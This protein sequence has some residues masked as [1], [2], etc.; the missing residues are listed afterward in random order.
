M[1]GLRSAG[2]SSKRGERFA[3]CT[4]LTLKY[5]GPYLL[6]WL[7]WHKLAGIERIF[8]YLDD[9]L[10]TDAHVHAPILDAV[11][12]VPWV[13]VTTMCAARTP[14]L[15]EVLLDCARRAKGEGFV[16]M[17][18]WDLDESPAFGP[19]LLGDAP[20]LLA[21]S[22]RPPSFPA[23]LA[24]AA[25]R[26][27]T[28]A[29]VITRVSFGDSGHVQPPA[30]QLESE[31]YT[32]RLNDVNGPGKL[33]WRLDEHGTGGAN[34]THIHNYFM[35]STHHIF[36]RYG[37]TVRNMDGS[38]ASAREDQRKWEATRWSTNPHDQGVIITA[39]DACEP[40]TTC[41]DGGSAVE[42]VD[43]RLLPVRLHHYLSRSQ[44][45]C[46]KKGRL[47][48]RALNSGAQRLDFTWRAIS[49]MN[50]CWLSRPG[51][52]YGRFTRDASL[53]QYAPA[54]RREVGRLFGEGA[55]AA[56]FA[57]T[58]ALRAE[59]NARFEPDR[60]RPNGLT[61]FAQ[62]LG[63]YAR[64]S[65]TTRAS[66][67]E[68]EGVDRNGACDWGR[69]AAIHIVKEPNEYGGCRSQPHGRLLAEKGEHPHGGHHHRPAAAGGGPPQSPSE[70]ALSRY[71]LALH[72][73]V[74][75][76]PGD[77]L[78]RFCGCSVYKCDWAIIAKLYGRA[79]CASICKTQPRKCTEQEE[80]G[81]N[82]LYPKA[83]EVWE[84]YVHTAEMCNRQMG[85]YSADFKM[86]GYSAEII[87]RAAPSWPI[88]LPEK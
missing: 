75:M 66:A 29:L 88:V 32:E 16:W 34:A 77:L 31:A 38:N 33:V 60:P 69:V 84:P 9:P 54:V 76:G 83:V 11:G 64:K 1:P 17:A 6:P 85:G 80:I 13:S 50:T 20:P 4:M 42:R 39:M 73:Y 82:L 40:D 72:C 23:L 51:R 18:N 58:D 5:E 43:E 27:P 30:G 35:Y 41:A 61:R 10:G 3:L 21:A 37:D 22:A 57:E 25:A 49:E 26:G 65:K 15:K 81:C 62:T 46:E 14:N 12:R 79:L 56:A 52:P 74:E 36:A 71:T 45:E 24:A 28:N 47:M 87:R 8:L 59:F 2:T 78:Q 67:C 86:G 70:L 68:G 48:K 63:C 55:L 44:A 7:A 53:A 19:P